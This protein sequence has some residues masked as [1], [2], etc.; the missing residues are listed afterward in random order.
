MSINGHQAT[1]GSVKCSESAEQIILLSIAGLSSTFAAFCLQITND[2]QAKK[3][4]V[5]R[6][7]FNTAPLLHAKRYNIYIQIQTVVD[8]VSLGD[9][10]ELINIHCTDLQSYMYCKS[11]IFPSN[12]ANSGLQV[13]ANI[14]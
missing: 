14:H 8:Q 7:V 11:E 4:E 2:L 3:L 1:P 6:P 10:R 13:N 9:Y 5:S 12:F